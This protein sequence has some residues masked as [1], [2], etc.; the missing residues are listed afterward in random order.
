MIVYISIGN[1]DDKL[2]QLEWCNYW[3]EMAARVAAVGHIHGS[4]HSS[5][6]SAYQNACWCVEYKSEDQVTEAREAA[7]EIREKYRQDS[8]AWAVADTEFL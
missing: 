4:W 7:T 6:V 2:T 8:V 3:T 5:P 1:S